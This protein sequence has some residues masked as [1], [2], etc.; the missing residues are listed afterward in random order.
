MRMITRN[1]WD[2]AVSRGD[3]SLSVVAGDQSAPSADSVRFR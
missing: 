1:I 3:L 2:T